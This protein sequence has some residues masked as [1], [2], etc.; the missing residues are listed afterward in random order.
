MTDP[1]SAMLALVDA[2]CEIVGGFRAGGDW[3]FR[4]D[5]GTTVKIEAVTRGSCWLVAADDPPTRLVAGDAVVLNNAGPAVF[6]SEP[7]LPP[8]EP[9]DLAESMDGSLVTLG[10]GDD[11]IVV[12]SHVE[13]DP[14]AAGL[15]TAGLA[16]VTHVSAASAEAEPMRR[17]LEQIMEEH[18]SGRP[19]ASFAIAHQAQLL[20]LQVLRV[21][22]QRGALSHSHPGWLRLIADPHLR[23]AVVLMHDD[24]AREWRLVDL[25]VAAGM[26]RSHFA[27]RFRET[28]GTSPLNYLA[29]WRVRLAEQALRD[30][31]TT[32]A[33]LADRL[34]YASESS[35]SH[36]FTRMSG[37]P[38][39]RYRRQ[40]AAR[41][42]APARGG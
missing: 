36:A 12:A 33:S 31:D 11:V 35:F 29:Q 10:S 40:R 42:P 39:S 38:P 5:A 25:A 28:S 34:G 8:V 16:P 20:L 17:L 2:R 19:G 32:V 21:G 15:F 3:A 22:V 9:D 30:T 7:G 41:K 6:C 13:L 27:H 14:A 4:F 1:L 23:P 18:V 37:M 26:S 24:P